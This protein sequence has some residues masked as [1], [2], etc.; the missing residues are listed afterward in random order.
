MKETPVQ[1]LDQEDP[2]QWR[3]GRLPTPVFLGF[4]GGTDGEESTC[5]VGIL[6]SIPGLG[7]S[8]GGGHGNPLQYSF[9]RIPMDR[10]AW[11]ATVHGVAKSRIRL[12][13][14]TKH[15]T[16]TVRYCGYLPSTVTWWAL[17]YRRYIMLHNVMGVKEIIRNKSV[18]LK[19]SWKER[20]PEGITWWM[21]WSR[22]G[23]EAKKFQ[24]EG[25]KRQF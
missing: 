15:S 14:W 1:F 23:E 8:P 4:P 20:R 6:G 19:F 9:L 21:D 2:L 16:A 22:W 11:R 25:R 18:H 17:A 5:N 3:S 7:K 12:S 13:D 10:G 24:G